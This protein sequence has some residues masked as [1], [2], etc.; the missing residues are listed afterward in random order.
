MKMRFAAPK[1]KFVPSFASSKIGISIVEPA[2]I[3]LKNG[4]SCLPT[5][6]ALFCNSYINSNFRA[7]IFID[8]LV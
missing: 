2:N 3:S 1:L 7:K 6:V 4:I 5:A 8:F